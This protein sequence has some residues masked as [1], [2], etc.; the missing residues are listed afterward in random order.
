MKIY[1]LRHE[2]RTMDATFF[3]PLT[4]DGLNNSVKLIPLLKMCK[5]NKIY[6]S[7]FIRTLQTIHPY[8]KQCDLNINIDYSLGEIQHPLIIPQK[9]YQI[10]LPLYLSK[11]FNFNDKYKSIIC[12]TEYTYPETEKNVEERVKKFIFKL[13]N[14][15]FKSK[16]NIIIVSH[17]VVCNIIL[18]IVNSKSSK[19]DITSTYPKGGLTQI[20]DNDKWV[21][22][23]INWEKK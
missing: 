4:E 5:I 8:A 22:K 7:P 13:I 15:E 2:D 17:Q 23:P 11:S 14:D 3:A 9:S 12:P 21:L 18:K 16:Y 10:T 19:I 6:S 1:I 20:F